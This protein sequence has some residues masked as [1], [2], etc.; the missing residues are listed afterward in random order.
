MPPTP[1]PKDA[2][3]RLGSVKTSA[4]AANLSTI[5]GGQQQDSTDQQV[6]QTTS[7]AKSDGYFNSF[8]TVVVTGFFYKYIFLKYNCNGIP[9]GIGYPQAGI[10]RHT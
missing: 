1:F 2:T 5:A 6:Q 3:K 8:W 10:R 9:A 4:A 7:L